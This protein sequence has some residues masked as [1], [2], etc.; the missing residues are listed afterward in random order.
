LV[1]VFLHCKQGLVRHVFDNIVSYIFFAMILGLIHSRVA[2]PIKAIATK[3]VDESLIVQVAMPVLAVSFAAVV[4]FVH[5]PGMHAANDIIKAYGTARPTVV[6]GVQQP[7]AGPEAMLDYF[8]QAIERGSFAHQEI[9]EQLAQQAMNLVR[10]PQVDQA[11]KDAFADYSE[12]QLLRL[13]EEKPGDARVHVFVASYY[14]A[15]N[16]L[17]KAAQEMAIARELSPNKQEIIIQQGFIEL[18]RNNLEAAKEFF[19]TAF[20]LDERNPAARE[21]YA[22][23]LLY[24]GDIAGA[25]ALLDTTETKTRFAN[26]DFLLGA[27]NQAG[28]TELLIELF[29][30]RVETDKT[31]AQNWASLSFLYYNQ[32]D[33]EKAIE[34]LS[35]AQVVVPTF[36]STSNCII[37]NIKTGKDPQEGC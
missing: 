22:A 8:K 9:T 31:N 4:Y 12:E 33:I 17:D 13:I 27:A 15:T 10:N 36:A 23:A 6:A 7:P 26:S 16:Q 24:T 32:G 20:E 37:D 35:E 28:A 2:T 14:R 30:H 1:K 34:T 11:I 21:Y 5:W 19:K 3:K 18:A 29:K 25:T